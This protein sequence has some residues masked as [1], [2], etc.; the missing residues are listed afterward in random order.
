MVSTAPDPVVLITGATG[1]LGRAATPLFALEGANLVLVGTDAG[2]LRS[3]AA[4]AALDAE[5]HLLVTAD[6]RDPA[7]AREMAEE[8]IARFGHIDVLLH[9]VGGWVGGTAV[10]DLD[11]DEVRRMLDQH[12]WS[13]LNVVQAVVPGMIERGFGRVLAISSPL[14]ANPGPKGASYAIAKSAEEVILRSLAKETA[15]TGVTANL[16][17]VRSI[18]SGNGRSAASA[19]APEEMA[20]V[21]AYLA[22]PGASAVTG[23]RIAIG[24]G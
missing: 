21:L 10:V 6:L 14:A 22:S 4:D 15:G 18:A 20:Q 3:V 19:T 1:P 24:A 16:L 12:L 11:H 13:T 5:R 2:R 9:A 23:Q 7:A 8:A 17:T